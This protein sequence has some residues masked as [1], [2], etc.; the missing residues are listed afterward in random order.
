MQRL[1]C[2]KNSKYKEIMT[3]KI[4]QNLNNKKKHS[5]RKKY[6]YQEPN[7]H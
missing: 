1:E 5:K 2:H 7:K 6:R 4:K 3:E